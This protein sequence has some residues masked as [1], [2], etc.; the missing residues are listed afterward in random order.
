MVGPFFLLLLC[1]LFLWY[2]RQAGNKK[3]VTLV[4]LLLLKLVLISLTLQHSAERVLPFEV[5]RWQLNLI[6]PSFHHGRDFEV[7]EI[8]FLRNRARMR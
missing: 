8:L 5:H 4:G 3:A 7:I 2:D 6:G 1:V